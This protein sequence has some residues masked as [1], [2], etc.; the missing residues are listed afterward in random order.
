MCAYQAIA[1]GDVSDS[2]GFFRNESA[3]LFVWWLE[4]YG[5][6]SE[7]FEQPLW[8]K[9]IICKRKEKCDHVRQKDYLRR[10]RH[11]PI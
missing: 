9:R 7:E 11:C 2:S 1:G 5:C 6:T 10:R 8:M 3:A 4:G